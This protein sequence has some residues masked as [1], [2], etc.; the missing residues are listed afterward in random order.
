MEGPPNNGPDKLT[1][2]QW[3]H[4]DRP[5][6]KL[7]DKGSNVLSDAE[8]LAILIRTGTPRQ[9][10]L[11]LARA[12]LARVEGDLDRLARLGVPDLMKVNGIKKAKAITIA[13]ALELGRRRKDGKP[14]ERSGIRSSSDA[15]QELRPMLADL[16]HEQFWLLFLDRGCRMIRSPFQ[17]SEGGMHGTVADPKLIFK[18]ALDNRAS[19]LVLAHNH[20]SGQLRPSEED[21][22]LTRKM[23]E[24]GRLLDIVV[25]DHIIIAG[26]GYFSFA[27]QGM[28]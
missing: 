20:P 9:N 6:E 17:L 5:R 10:A 21:L 12:I 27:D 23:V 3:A 2:R 26:Q 15:Y 14:R 1:I 24:A 8:L 11:D 4:D 7:L 28:L 22:Q 16:G 18:H 13:A 25:Q 19:S